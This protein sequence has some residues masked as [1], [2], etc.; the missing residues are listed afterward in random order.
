MEGRATMPRGE[1]AARLIFWCGTFLF[2][3]YLFVKSW[4]LSS[5]D[6]ALESRRID[7]IAFWAAAR[8]ALAGVPLAAFDPAALAEAAGLD[9][10]TVENLRWLYPPGF[11][12]LIAPVG[13]LPYWAAWVA[14]AFVSAAALAFA[15]REPARPLPGGWRLVV[16]APVTLIGCLAIGQTSLL[17]TAGLMAALWAMRRE[18]RVAAGAWIALL[19]LKPQ[20]GILIPVALVAARDWRT[21]AA[22]TA[23]AAVVILGPTALFGLEYWQHFL[24][25]LD[26]TV[27]RME[28]G[29]VLDRL[30]STYGFLRAAGADHATALA[31]Q[32]VATVVLGAAVAWTWRRTALGTDLKFAVLCAAIP[33]ATPYAYYYE[34]VLTLA[35]GVFL[36]RDGFGKG[37][38]ARLWLLAIWLGPVPALYLPEMTTVAIAA[39]PLI[40][41][42]LGVCL[43][44][45][46]RQLAS[47]P[48]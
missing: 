48:A 1:I 29:Y 4:E 22:A 33:L 18:R 16:V 17:W 46:W 44:R 47:R 11:H 10:G 37:H 21:I 28:R 25:D 32:L 12:A 31:S 42:T 15:A 3:L 20:L 13:L 34:M 26:G 35:A 7:F 38:L 30:V 24:A 19:T 9:A 43:A 41:G 36:V 45:A 2:L 6:P 23:I 5:G 40:A 8:L 39:P 14:F 27:A